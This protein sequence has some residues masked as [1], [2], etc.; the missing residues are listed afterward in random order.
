MYPQSHCN[1]CKPSLHHDHDGGN[2]DDDFD[3]DD[4]DNGDDGVIGF[5]GD[6]SNQ[7]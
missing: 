1:I 4:D 2:H 5:L 3:I 7:V 6:H